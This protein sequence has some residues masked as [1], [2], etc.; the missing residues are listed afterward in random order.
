MAT[1]NN[2]KDNEIGTGWGSI[3]GEWHVCNHV[4][5][6]LRTD[7]TSFFNFKISNSSTGYRATLQPTIQHLAILIS[8]RD[9]CLVDTTSNSSLCSLS[10]S[11]NANIG[12]E[13]LHNNVNVYRSFKRLAASHLF[14]HCEVRNDN[15][16]R[17]I[18][19]VISKLK[20]LSYLGIYFWPR[21]HIWPSLWC[22]KILCGIFQ[23]INSWEVFLFVF[24]KSM[25]DWKKPHR[26]RLFDLPCPHWPLSNQSH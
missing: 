17:I 1:A 7:A 24:L 22:W 5:H 10:F 15:I 6:L 19:L 20:W 26:N 23:S 25:I 9:F 2:I 21:W 8:F 16:L 18:V 4:P 14:T 13:C 11:F 12:C 3:S